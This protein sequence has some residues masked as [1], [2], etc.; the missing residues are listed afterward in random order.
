M[1]EREVIDCASAAAQLDCAALERRLRERARFALKLR[2]GAPLLHAQALR[3]QCGGLQGL[4]RALASASA[5]VHELLRLARQRH[6]DLDELPWSHI[7]QALV[8]WQPHARRR[9]ARP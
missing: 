7:V 9:P 4:Q 2:T 3:L 6:G 1:A 8:Q 5:D